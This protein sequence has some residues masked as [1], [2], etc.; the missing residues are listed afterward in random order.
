MEPKVSIIMPIYNAEKFLPDTLNSVIN[1]TFKNIEI[2]CVDDGS[3]DN[4]VRILKEYS[5]KDSRIRILQQKNQYA[6][7][8]RN[9]GLAHAT[10]DYVMFL[11]SDDL[12]EKNMVSYLVKK[13]D[14]YKPDIIVFG[15]YRFID[16]PKK[17]RPVKNKYKN[18][19]VCSSKDIKESIFQI[20]RSMPWDKFIRR[21]FLKKT[22]ILYQGTKVNNDIF[23][24]RLIVT[25]AER[26]LFC[27]KRLVNYKISNNQSLQGKLNKNPTDFIAGNMG[28]YDELNRR[29]S[30]ATF[31]ESYNLMAVNDIIIHL[32]RV[33]SYEEFLQIYSELKKT[34]FFQK[35][36][37]NSASNIIQQHPFKDTLTEVIDGQPEKSIAKMCVEMQKTTIGKDSIEYI[38]G[39]T[40]LEIL[41][42]TF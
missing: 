39:R 31:K 17:R 13:A 40:I 8:A 38:I 2:I 25:E 15:Y 18:M 23:F 11:D 41:G 19:M 3:T 33:D 5:Q 16:S 20:T 9:N 35:I 24:N 26:I 29:K 7:I 10:G 6:G 21:D 36:G 1:Q 37:I 27:S 14:K 12:F 4:S 34:Q 32:K 30:Y 42:L 28:I 22:G